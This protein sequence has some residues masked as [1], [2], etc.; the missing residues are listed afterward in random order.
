MAWK[1]PWNKWENF[2]YRYM[3]PSE[4][5]LRMKFQANLSLFILFPHSG[6][7]SQ[8]QCLTESYSVIS[9]HSRIASESAC[10]T[11]YSSFLSLLRNIAAYILNC[12]QNHFFQRCIFRCTFIFNWSM[13]PLHFKKV[14]QIYYIYIYIYKWHKISPNIV[15]LFR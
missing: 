4:H 5:L 7:I 10:R 6:W 9:P 13:E 8:F 3:Q 14:F 15:H 1:R 11:T 12:Y 2:I